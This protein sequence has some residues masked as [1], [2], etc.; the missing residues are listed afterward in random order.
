MEKFVGNESKDSSSPFANARVVEVENL[1]KNFNGI[2]VVDNV[3]FGIEKG[4]IVG[5]LGPN[6]AGKTTTIMMLLGITKPTSGKIKIFGLDFL[7]N[8]EEILGK[9][10]FSSAYTF[11]PG[12]LTVFENLYVFSCLY[13]ISDPRQKIKELLN[14]FGLSNLEDKST[15]DLSS[16]QLTCLNLCKALLND[17]EV[18]FLDEPTSSLDPEIAIRVRQLLFKIRRERNISMLYTSHNM[19]EITQMCDKVI[20]LDR[21]KI[22]VSDTPLNLTKMIKDCFLKLTFDTPLPKVKEFCQKNNLNFQIPQPN[23]LEITLKEEEIGKTLTNLAF[24]GIEIT[25]VIIERPDLEDVFLKI[26][27]QAP[28]RGEGQDERSSS[29]AKT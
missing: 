22:V 12:R 21:G 4:E 3:S 24:Q 10:N 5:L 15:W 2:R 20:F 18:L 8:R 26:A 9:V 29:P 1:T 19:E 7:P 14:N 16:G 23:V 11:L 28:E 6:G 27:Q 25:D 17:P 13:G